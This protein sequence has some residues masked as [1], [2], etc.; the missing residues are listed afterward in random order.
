MLPDCDRPAAAAG[1]TEPGADLLVAVVSY[2]TRDLLDACLVSLAE[3]VSRAGVAAGV[4]VVDNASADGSPDMVRQRH[5][6]ARLVP[7]DRNLG[8]AA[9]AN[10]ALRPAIEVAEGHGRSGP[11]WALVLNSDVRLHPDALAALL[12]ALRARP[13][14]ALAGPALVYPDGRFQHAAFRFPGLLQTWID[15]LD[16][17]RVADGAI[18]GRYPKSLYKSGQPFRVDFP[19]GACMLVRVEAMRQVGLMDEG[20]FLYC[21]EVDWCRRFRGAGWAVLCVPGA[22]AVHHSGASTNAAGPALRRTL[23][24]SRR[25]YYA[26]HE[27]PWRYALLSASIAFGLRLRPPEAAR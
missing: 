23:W 20:F 16:I 5:P 13:D 19:L 7:L 3:A 9:A 15:L 27:P 22:V 12:E 18:N 2:N 6:W 11:E 14:A 1:L 21:E 26:K 10:M 8:Y 24:R 17:H 25:R 4:Q